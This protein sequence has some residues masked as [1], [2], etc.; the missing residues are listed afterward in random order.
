MSK[1]WMTKLII[2][3][4]NNHI[5]NRI[6]NDFL[7]LITISLNKLTQIWWTPFPKH[8]IIQINN[9][10]WPSKVLTNKLEKPFIIRFKIVYQFSRYFWINI[11]MCPS[12]VFGQTRFHPIGIHITEESLGLTIM[13]VRPTYIRLQSQKRLYWFKG[14]YGV[15]NQ[16]VAIN[17]VDLF[18]WK[19]LK[20]EFGVFI[21][22]WVKDWFVFVVDVSVMTHGVVLK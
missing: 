1:Y 7:L 17:K 19:L 18:S 20:P 9:S 12:F 4:D 14:R 2:E 11:W 16:R 13:K 6:N 3:T 10:R 5:D 15:R 22:S 8:F 21:I